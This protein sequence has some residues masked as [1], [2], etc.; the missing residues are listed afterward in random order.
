[1]RNVQFPWLEQ[2][3]PY[4]YSFLHRLVTRVVTESSTLVVIVIVMIVQPIANTAKPTTSRD[5]PDSGAR[6]SRMILG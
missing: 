2:G 4:A 3:N 1:M 5:P 6:S